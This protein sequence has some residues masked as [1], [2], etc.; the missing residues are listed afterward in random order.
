MAMYA[1][2][3]GKLPFATKRPQALLADIAKNVLCLQYK[4]ETMKVSA[5]CGDLLGRLLTA[6]YK[7]RI[8]KLSFFD[9]PFVRTPPEKYRELLASASPRTGTSGSD[10]DETKDSLDGSGETVFYR[11]SSENTSLATSHA[12]SPKTGSK[13]D[14]S[15]IPKNK[16]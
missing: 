14:R 1:M 7:K 5:C 12:G 11:S 8:D 2:L 16:V 4:L 9:H 13:T 6:D 10:R 3:N 15:R